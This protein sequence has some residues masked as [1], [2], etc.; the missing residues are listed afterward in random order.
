[1]WDTACH[2]PSRSPSPRAHPHLPSCLPHH[3]PC[4][5]SC[6]AQRS[7]HWPLSGGSLRVLLTQPLTQSAL[8][9]TPQFKCRLERRHLAGPALPLCN[10]EVPS[11]PPPA[12][13]ITSCLVLGTTSTRSYIPQE[14]AM[15]F[16]PWTLRYL[17]P[18][19]AHSRRSLNAYCLELRCTEFLETSSSWRTTLAL[20]MGASAQ[21]RGSLG[22]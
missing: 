14:P 22:L 7:P 10:C 12:G 16:A 5:P 13:P 6:H 4:P 8:S 2:F 1:M 18:C 19:P 11:L 15:P 9:L 20:S 17:L 21:L 3:L